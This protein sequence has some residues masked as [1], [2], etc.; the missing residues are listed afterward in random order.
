[1]ETSNFLTVKETLGN[2]NEKWK[3]KKIT[4]SNKSKQEFK[5]PKLGQFIIYDAKN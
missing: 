2:R 4:K 1:M 3:V 5:N